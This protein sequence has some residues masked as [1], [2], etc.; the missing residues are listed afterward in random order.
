M[1]ATVN[2]QIQPGQTQTA[3]VESVTA[4]PC[5]ICG[6]NTGVG[7]VFFSDR[8]VVIGADG[9]QTYLCTLDDSRIRA[10]R[11]GKRL[12]DDQVRQLVEN[13]SA[14]ATGWRP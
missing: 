1:R 4:E 8:H 10:S 11:R 6:E 12:T 14:I 5:L 9:R 7:S 2:S 13:G 3:A